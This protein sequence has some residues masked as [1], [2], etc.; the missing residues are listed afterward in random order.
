MAE[1]TK[2]LTPEEKQK[3]LIMVTNI[4]IDLWISKLFEGKVS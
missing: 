3:R 2:T 1:K 4:A